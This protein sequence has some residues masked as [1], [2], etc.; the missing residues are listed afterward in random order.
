MADTFIVAQSVTAIGVSFA[1]DQDASG[2]MWPYA[3]LAFGAGGTQTEVQAA[4]PLPVGGTIAAVSA[5]LGGT[6]SLVSAVTSVGSIVAALPAGTNNIGT[7]GQSGTWNIAGVTSVGSIVSPLPAGGNSIGMTQNIPGTTGGLLQKSIISAAGLNLTQVKTS[8]G[9]VYF[10][11]VQNISA[12][13]VYLK[14]FD[15]AGTVNVTMGTTSATYQFMAPTNATA[16]NGTGIVMQF[17]PGV[18]HSNGVQFA[19]T[20]SIGFADNTSI[21]ASIA[22]VTVG[23][24]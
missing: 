20:G 4:S 10:I 5:L 18:A 19:L 12:T 21:A 14:I 9:Q 6:I 24:K 7:V 8:A 17:D 13:P 11:S 15:L 3:K 23:Y 2:G 16:A 22:I 1:V